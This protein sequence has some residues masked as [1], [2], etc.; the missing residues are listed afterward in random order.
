[1]QIN[2]KDTI[3]V[4]YDCFDQKQFRFGTNHWFPGIHLAFM[5][6]GCYCANN[7]V[8]RRS[9]NRECQLELVLF[10]TVT[11]ESRFVRGPDTIKWF[12]AESGL[13]RFRIDIEHNFVLIVFELFAYI[14]VEIT[15]QWRG[16]SPQHDIVI[17]EFELQL[18]Y[19]AHFRTNSPGKTYNT[20]CIPPVMG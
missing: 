17:T 19:L 15:F 12:D 20:P 9:K 13:V 11:H 3:N 16:K 8:L 2:L 4:F 5:P 6:S 7:L 14:S 18:F 10:V 1:M